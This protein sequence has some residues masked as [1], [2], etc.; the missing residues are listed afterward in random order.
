[1]TFEEEFPSLSG[2]IHGED[3]RITIEK[4]KDCCLDKERVR[5]AIENQ[6]YKTEW[7][8]ILKKEMLLKELGL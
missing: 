4:I 1:M 8:N 3:D 5:N 2:I 6:S 7:G